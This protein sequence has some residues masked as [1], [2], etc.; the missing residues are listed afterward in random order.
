MTQRRLVLD[1]DGTLCTET[2]GEYDRA[3]PLTDRILKVRRLASEGWKVTIDSA[4]GS[5]TGVDWLDE[6][7]HQL[8]RW[9]V[10]YDELRVGQKPFGHVYVDNRAVSA[11]D[12]FAEEAGHVERWPDEYFAQRVGNDPRRVASFVSEL[13]FLRQHGVTAE[14]SPHFRGAVCDVG[15]STGEFLEFAGWAGAAHGM[16]ISRHAREIA[17][18]KGIDFS[19]NIATEREY[20]D[21]VIL[22]GVLQHLPDPG[23]TLQLAYRALKPGGSLAILATPNTDSWCYRLL[24]NFPAP[25][26]DPTRNYFFPSA[27]QLK[28]ALWNY[29]FTDIVIEFPYWGGPYARPLHDGLSFARRLLFGQ[30]VPFAFPRNLMNVVARKPAPTDAVRDEFCRRY[31]R[32]P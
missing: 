31:A 28:N 7:A 26:N 5:E 14:W 24:G 32:K 23:R 15:C 18:S 11:D 17:E 13:A 16:E 25:L 20:F 21:C 27:R 22:R 2:G 10:P 9:G 6:T 1:L 3:L 30:W 8:R 4:R 12:F 29:G 19:R